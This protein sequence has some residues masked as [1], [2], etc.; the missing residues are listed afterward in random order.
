MFLIIIIFLISLLNALYII[1]DDNT[2]V[3]FKFLSILLVFFIIYKSTFKQT[4]LE[5]LGSSAYPIALIPSS[6]T[7]AKSNYSIEMDFDVPNGSKIIYWASIG[8]KDK[9]K[10]FGNP[11][12]AYGNYENSGVAVVNDKK[13]VLYLNCPNKYKV[14]SGKIL[15]QHIHYRIAYPNNPILSDVRTIF[16]NC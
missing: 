10:I 1:A 2:S 5:F 15:D 13:T 12:D 7:P 11:Y 9:K 6:I 4:Y 8:D 14:P 16:F 3:F